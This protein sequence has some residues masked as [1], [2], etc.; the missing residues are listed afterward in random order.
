ML[1]LRPLDPRTKTCTSFVRERSGTLFSFWSSKYKTHLCK[2][3]SLVNDFSPKFCGRSVADN[4][5][6]A[7]DTCYGQLRMRTM[8]EQTNQYSSSLSFLD[9][10]LSLIDSIT[11]YCELGCPLQGDGRRCWGLFLERPETFRVT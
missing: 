8:S 10:K 2:S 11:V 7:C 1:F 4:E 5:F 3:R 6:P 9:L